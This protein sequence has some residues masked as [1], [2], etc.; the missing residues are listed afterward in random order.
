MK[1]L[2]LDTSS[3]ACSVAAAAGERRRERHEIAP[4]RHRELILPMVDTVLEEA[5]LG[6]AELDALVVGA[7]PGSFIGVRIG[8]ALA[9]GLAQGAGLRLVVASSLGAVAE[10]ALE[11]D[12]SARVLVAQ[13]ARMGE[14]YCGRYA[15]DES[16]GLRA[17]AP[18]SLLEPADLPLGAQW[19]LAGAAWNEVDALRERR[20]AAGAPAPRVLYP[21]ARCLLAP[22]ARAVERGE[23]VAP[24]AA[25]PAYLRGLAQA[26]PTS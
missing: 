9:Q 19:A 7:G 16:G 4:R 14:I 1:L 2:A 20:E 6:L 3:D 12:P 25:E 8:F 23:T 24:E 17:L 13:D 15:R 5:D 18:D 10:E 22:G 26:Y 11:A 21:R